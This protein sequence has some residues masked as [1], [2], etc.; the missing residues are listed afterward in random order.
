MNA[1]TNIKCFGWY[2]DTKGAF[3]YLVWDNG[4]N[5]IIEVRV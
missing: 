5:K 4:K 2:K 3:Y 1:N